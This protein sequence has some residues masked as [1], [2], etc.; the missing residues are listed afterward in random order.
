VPLPGKEGET[1]G[2]SFSSGSPFLV[3]GVSARAIVALIRSTSLSLS[4]SLTEYSNRLDL[5]IFQGKITNKHRRDNRSISA[6]SRNHTPLQKPPVAAVPP[7]LP[8]QRTN[9]S[10][11]PR[12]ATRNI[13]LTPCGHLYGQSYIYIYIHIGGRG[14]GKRREK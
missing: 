1:N 10:L 12:H 5:I 6:K 9:R 13:N 3:A 7:P 11:F 2:V 14:R 4:L 8:S